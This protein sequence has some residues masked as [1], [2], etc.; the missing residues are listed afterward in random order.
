MGSKTLQELCCTTQMHLFNLCLT[1]EDL[2]SLGVWQDAPSRLGYSPEVWCRAF[3]H[4]VCQRDAE[5]AR[6]VG[7]RLDLRYLD[8]VLLVRSMGTNEL[9]RTVDLWV[10]D[11]DGAA[12]PGLVWSFCTD[13]RQE[14]RN[15]G[16]RLCHEAVA[17]ACTSLVRTSGEI[18]A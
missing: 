10:A 18:P 15:L 11:P 16:G 1:R 8:T 2:R 5:V 9:K 17:R 4:Q 3:L 7:D 13:A 6:T 12:L 14:A